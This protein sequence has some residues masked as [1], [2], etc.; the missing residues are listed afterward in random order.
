VLL[1]VLLPGMLPTSGCP[2]L[3]QVSSDESLRP[4]PGQRT[5]VGAQTNSGSERYASWF[6]DSDGH[7]L[8]FGLSPFLETSKQCEKDGGMLCSLRDLQQPG[9]HLIGRFDM[10]DERFLDPLLVRPMDPRAPSSV[11]DVLVHSNGRIYYTTFWD[12]FGSVRPDGSDVQHYAGAGRGLNELWEGPDGEIYVTRYL[13]K[14]PGVAVFDPDGVLR[15]ELTMPQEKGTL[16]CPKSLAVDPRTGDIWINTDIFHD[17]RSPV[18]FDSFRLSPQGDILERVVTPV[19][20]FMSFD[21]AGRGWFVDDVAGHWI[22][23]IVEPDSSTARLDLGPHDPIDVLQ[24]IRHFGDVTLLSTW[25]QSVHAV[26]RRADGGY[27]QCTLDVEQAR[28]CPEG[29]SLGYTAALSTRGRVYETV[30]CAIRIVRAG[31]LDDCEWSDQ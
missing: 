3:R 9:D 7:V 29:V 19:L 23:R 30:D 5:F 20:Q 24:D 4:A 2:R 8:Y 31:A 21:Q 15:R 14:H 10:D 6:G 25:W 22:L 1:G 18:T 16:I 11:W 26:R 12:E 28:D 27:E 17:D 13:G